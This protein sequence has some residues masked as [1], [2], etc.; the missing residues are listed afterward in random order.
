VSKRKAELA[1]IGAASVN[2][3]LSHGRYLHGTGEGHVTI[4]RKVHSGRLSQNNW[5]QHSYQT[6][7]LY[8]VLPAYGGVY[9]AYIS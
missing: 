3:P 2:S 4:A 8:D 1:V 7:E 9:D 5:E 6:R